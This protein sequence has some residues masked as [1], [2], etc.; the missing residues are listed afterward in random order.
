MISHDFE[1]LAD[2]A[3]EV[4]YLDA[5]SQVIDLYNMCSKQYLKRCEQGQERRKRGVQSLSKKQTH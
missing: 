4:F 1:L 3:D 5:N 2:I